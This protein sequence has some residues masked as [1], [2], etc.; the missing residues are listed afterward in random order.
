MSRTRRMSF[1]SLTVPSL[2]CRGLAT[3]GGSATIC[4][5]A[6]T[7]FMRKATNAFF[8]KNKPRWY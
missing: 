3:A 6:G 4:S 2:P 5:Y 1:Q 7:L 8:A